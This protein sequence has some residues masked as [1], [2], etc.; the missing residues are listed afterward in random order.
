VDGWLDDDL[1]FVKG[2]GFELGEIAV[3]TVIW[4][5]SQDLMV[6]FGHGQWLSAQLPNASAHLVAGEGHLS[7]GLGAIGEMLDELVTA[8][9]LA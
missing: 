8:G 7:V 2:W 4:Q 5:G 1:A 9:H 6:P 3:P